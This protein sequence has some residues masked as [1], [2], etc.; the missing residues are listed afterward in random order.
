MKISVASIKHTVF[1]NSL[2]ALIKLAPSA[3]TPMSFVG[4]GSTAQLSEHIARL[5]VKRVLIVSDKPLVELGIVAR[6]GDVL[7][8]AGVEVTIYDGVLPDPT[9]D[10]VEA[11]LRLQRQHQCDCV[12]AIGGGSA[13]DTAKTIA[14]A[15]TNGG[16][17]RAMVGYFKAKI[18]PLPLFA[19]PTTSGTGSEVTFGAVISDAVSHEKFIVGDSKIVPKAVA[20]DPEIITGLPPAITAATGMDALTHAVEA[21]LSSWATPQ[22]DDYAKMAVK[23]IFENLPIAYADGGNLHAREQMS[24]AAYYAGLCINAAAV[25]NVHAIAHQLGAWYGT[26]HGLANAVVMPEVLRFSKDAVVDRLAE[27]A[28]LIELG[29]RAD[30]PSIKADNFINAV[31]QLNESFGIS[32]KL[33]AIRIPDITAIATRAVKEGAGYPVPKLMDQQECEQMIRAMCL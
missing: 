15:A 32:A 24:I 20:L 3:T 12:L 5:G 8:A 29:N 9:F 13:I 27:L 17:A 25:G 10:L 18:Q 1:I 6:A 11:G 2:K 31:V 30:T 26:P 21:Y 23:M 28:D 22:N 16:S 14:A 4:A 7:T 19:I 33:D